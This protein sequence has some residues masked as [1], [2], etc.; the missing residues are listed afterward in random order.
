MNYVFQ[1]NP[2]KENM[3]KIEIYL[4]NATLPDSRKF[5]LEQQVVGFIVESPLADRQSGSGSFD[6]TN[7]K[8]KRK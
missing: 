1:R 6:L 3:K 8:V 7:L 4:N 5:S 2:F